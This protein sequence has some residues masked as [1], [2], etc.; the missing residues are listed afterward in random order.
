MTYPAGNRN[1]ARV[2]GPPNHRIEFVFL[3]RVK[4]TDELPRRSGRSFIANSGDVFINQRRVYKRIFPRQMALD[5][6]SDN[7]GEL[8]DLEGEPAILPR[9]QSQRIFVQPN[10]SA[11]IARIESAIES[12]LG[13]EVN[14]FAELCVEKQ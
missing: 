7:G 5:V 3:A 1:A 2:T 12:R 13:E 9:R 4:S 8:A 6:I 11:V 10:G 14:L